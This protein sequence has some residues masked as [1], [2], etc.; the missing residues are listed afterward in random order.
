MEPEP[1][2]TTKRKWQILSIPHR[3]VMIKWLSNGFTP[4][5]VLNRAPV[6]AQIPQQTTPRIGIWESHAWW[7]HSDLDDADKNLTWTFR[8]KPSSNLFI[9]LDTSRVLKVSPLDSNWHGSES[10]RLIVEDSGNGAFRKKDS[11]D[12]VFVVQSVNDPPVVTST[13]LL[14]TDEDTLYTYTIEATDVDAG[15]ALTYSASRIP[16][17]LTFDAVTMVWPEHPKT[18]MWAFTI[19]FCRYPTVLRL[20]IIAFNWG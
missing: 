4:L 19:W 16:V 11:T 2:L 10:V 12:V 5:T 15:D 7:F 9:T 20:R 1:E 8:Q 17:W 18:R 6:I 3:R 14:L 13:P